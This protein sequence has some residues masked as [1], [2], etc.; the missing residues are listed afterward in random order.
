MNATFQQISLSNGALPNSARRAKRKRMPALALLAA[1]AAGSLAGAATPPDPLVGYYGNTLISERTIGLSPYGGAAHVWLERDG[2][3]IS[4]DVTTG[5]R[6][7]TYF[8]K[9]EA[10]KPQLCLN[11]PQPLGTRCY[12]IE[13]HVVGDAWI[14]DDGDTFG[15]NHVVAGHQ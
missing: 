7:G 13:P 5:G 2:T 6:S 14:S 1:A 3:Y 9:W 10:S 12:P 11:Y 8:V 4:F 15:V